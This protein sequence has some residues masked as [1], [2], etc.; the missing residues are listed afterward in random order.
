MIDV[1]GYACIGYFV[2]SAFLAFVC[3]AAASSHRRMFSDRP[4]NLGIDTTDAADLHGA[5]MPAGSGAVD[6]ATGAA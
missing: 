5:S 3:W 2:L 1:F 4:D 6:R